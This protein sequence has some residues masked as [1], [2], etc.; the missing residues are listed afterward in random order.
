M[1]ALLQKMAFKYILFSRLTG[2]AFCLFLSGSILTPPV[3][4]VTPDSSAVWQ[5]KAGMSEQDLIGHFSKIME[6]TY[7]IQGG[8]EWITFED[9]TA[10]EIQLLT[11][12]LRQ[13]CVDAWSRD[14]RAEVAREYAGEFSSAALAISPKFS[15]AIRDVLARIPED[16]FLFLTRRAHPVLF[17]EYYAGLNARL[18]TSSDIKVLHDDPPTFTDGMWLVRLDYDLERRAGADAIK[19]IVAHELAHRVLQEKKEEENGLIETEKSV[20]RLI[21]AWGFKKE[22]LEAKRL[23]QTHQ[24]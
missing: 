19:A 3:L 15:S 23:T 11:F 2:I 13:G 1:R 6:R 10:K 20:N 9:H 24:T 14:D 16:V 7:R 18:S 12:Y 8:E 21:Q 5:P 22:F 17:V 4:A